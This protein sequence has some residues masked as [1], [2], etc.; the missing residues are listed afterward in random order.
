M[1]VLLAMCMGSK[2]RVK[3]GVKYGLC[4]TAVIM[5]IGFVGLEIF[6]N[7]FAGT[8]IV[9]QGI[10]FCG[11]GCSWYVSELGRMD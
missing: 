7:P 9:F 4:Y 2:E 8:N 11:T 5:L 1:N 6:A 10:W 3:D